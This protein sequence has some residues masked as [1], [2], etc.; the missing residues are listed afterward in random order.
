MSSS[1]ILVT[2][3]VGS[4]GSCDPLGTIAKPSVTLQNGDFSRGVELSAVFN[5]VLQYFLIWGGSLLTG[6]TPPC[7]TR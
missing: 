1:Q 5:E 7:G 3:I 2:R 4:V 6:C